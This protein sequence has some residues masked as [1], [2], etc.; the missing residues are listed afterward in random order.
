[1]LFLT[2]V[3]RLISAAILFLTTLTTPF[4]AATP[5]ILLRWD[6]IHFQHIAQHG[7]A[8]EHEWAFLPV[9]P[10][11][12]SK[13]ILAPTLV[14]LI[15][16]Y[17]MT[18][19]MYQ[20]SLHHLR[21]PSLARL[22]TVLSLLPSSPATLFLVPYNEPF[23][24]YF[25]YKG[26]LYCAKFRYVA[27]AIAFALAATFRANGIL[28]SGFI[29]WGL[30]IEPFLQ[31]RQA[32]WPSVHAMRATIL[33]LLPLIPFIAHNYAAYLSFCASA[34]SP[35]PWCARSLPLIYSY[36][37][38]T[39]WD[40]GFLRYWTLQQLPN[41]LI[42]APPL[43]LISIF[44]SYHLRW[45]AI[46]SDRPFCSPSIAPHAIHALVMCSILA[47]ASHTQIALRFAAA[48]PI[49]YWAAAWLLVEYP[50]WGRAW[51]AWSVL[52]GTTSIL[53]WGAFLP[54]A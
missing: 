45:V 46:A 47:L 4:D 30:V 39:Y 51:V 2:L 35:A 22:A 24:T 23:F 6:V 14:S 20:L 28:S 25:S 31:R 10:F 18:S 8:F 21:S 49:T 50:V 26:M 54:P 12:L 33:S 32:C 34:S 9:V 17:D 40:V 29:F 3:S 7:Y 13:F 19:T 48:M 15:V 5:H 11:L 43:L 38:S 36:I 37:Q 27:A 52:W 44:S 42:A 41:F 53:L 16:A 1:M